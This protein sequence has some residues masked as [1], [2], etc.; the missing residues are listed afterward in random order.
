MRHAY[1]IIVH[2]DN[3]VLEKLIELIDDR[4][5]DIFIHVDKKTKNFSFE[6]YKKIV[7][8]SNINF[9]PRVKVQ[10]G[11]YSL[12]KVELEL[13]KCANSYGDYSYFHLISGA[14]LPL[15]TQDEI[16]KFFGQINGK[17]VIGFVNISKDEY[18][19]RIRY[20]YFEKLNDRNKKILAYIKRGI[21]RFIILIQK[22]FKIERNKNIELAKGSQWFSITKNYLNYIISKEKQIEEIYKYSYCGDELFIQTLVIGTEYE[23]KLYIPKKISDDRAMRFIDW[24]RGRPYVFREAD[25]EQLINSKMLFARKFSDKVDKRIVEKIYNYLKNK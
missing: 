15:K 5:N 11:G 24:E 1:L 9:I 18:N 23:E 25:F 4:R 22:I 17:E 6:K 7:K 20:Y 21:R 19:D 16:H 13:M 12:V 2:E 14:D 3:Y 10:W 8:N